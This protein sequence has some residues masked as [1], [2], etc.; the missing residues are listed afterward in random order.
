MTEQFNE[1]K[2]KAKELATAIEV[3]VNAFHRETGYTPQVDIKKK[4]I[5]T[6]DRVIVKWDVNIQVMVE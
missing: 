6:N 4:M 5:K 1:I 3:L 2:A